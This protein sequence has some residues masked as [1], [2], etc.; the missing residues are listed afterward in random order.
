MCV[1]ELRKNFIECK[2]YE[3]AHHNEL[4]DFAQQEYLKGTLTIGEYKSIVKELELIGAQK[5]EFVAAEE[6]H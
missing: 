3:P 4:L 5:P 6:Q 1:N 2:Q